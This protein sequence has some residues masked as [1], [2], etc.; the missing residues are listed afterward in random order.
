MADTTITQT[1]TRARESRAAKT[2]VA[3]VFVAIWGLIT[4]GTFAGSGD[5]PHYLM[6]AR[7]VAFDADFD[8]AN[9][10]AD[11]ASLIGAGTLTPGLH[12]RPGIDGTLRPVHDVGL[13]L[14]AAPLVR[15]TYP[16]AE[17]LGRALP[18]AFLEKAK[19]NASLIHRHF[20]SLAM[21]IVAG[22]LAV[23]LRRLLL[24]AGL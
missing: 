6:I 7:S 8:L 22:L 15:L 19:L 20:L 3:L 1:P 11:P 5:D 10:Y 14:L 17:W 23:E 9:D 2:L 21:A 4:H 24:R 12:V 13:P 18:P 16:L